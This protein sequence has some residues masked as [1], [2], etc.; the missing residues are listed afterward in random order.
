MMLRLFLIRTLPC[1]AP[2][3]HSSPPSWRPSCLTGSASFCWCASATRSPRGTGPLP[4]S[5]SRS[6]S[7]LWSWSG[8]LSLSGTRTPGCGGWYWPL[9]SWSASGP[10]PSSFRSRGHGGICPPPPGRD[11][12]S[13]IKGRSLSPFYIWVTIL[14]IHPQFSDMVNQAREESVADVM[15]HTFKSSTATSM[16][17]SLVHRYSSHPE[18]DWLSNWIFVPIYFLVLK[19]SG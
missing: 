2:T 14:N 11:F 13:S 17:R 7:G 5:A 1:W 10:A 4:G 6:P 3:L 15:Y 8:T 12:S 18:V 9:A 16:I 19:I